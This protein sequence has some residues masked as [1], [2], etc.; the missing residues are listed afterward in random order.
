MG[1]L[2]R[3]QGVFC[4]LFWTPWFWRRCPKGEKLN[5]ILQLEEMSLD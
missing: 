5:E 3:G 2:T 4:G 1:D